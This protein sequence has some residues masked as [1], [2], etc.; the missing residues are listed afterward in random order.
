MDNCRKTASRVIDGRNNPTNEELVEILKKAKEPITSI[1]GLF[2][3]VPI[4][5]KKIDELN[6]KAAEN[7]SIAPSALCDFNQPI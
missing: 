5:K 2:D 1:G 4:T 6:R 7:D 3:F